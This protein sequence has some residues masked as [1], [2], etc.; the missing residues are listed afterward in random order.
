MLHRNIAVGASIGFAQPHRDR[1][2]VAVDL[3][4]CLHLVVSLHDIRLINA[5]GVDPEVDVLISQPHV[6]QEPPK[7]VPNREP[8]S[9]E[10]DNLVSHILAPS[11]GERDI[12]RIAAIER[13]GS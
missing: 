6:V 13:V 11:I 8:S 7:V 5:N 12:F 3:P 10:V 1:L 9:I 4:Y 2:G